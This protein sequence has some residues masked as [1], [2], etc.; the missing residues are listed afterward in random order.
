MF[1]NYK[2]DNIANKHS[3]N[4]DNIDLGLINSIRR[5]ILSEI[6][7]VAFY[8]EEHP[9]IEILYNNTP[10]HNEFMIHR[11]GLIP[12]HIKENIVENYEDNDYTFEL[13]VENNNPDIKMLNI[14]T[15]DFT[16]TYKDKVLTSKE[17][18]EI[19]PPNPITKN[20]I[21]ITRLR[22]NEKIHLKA[23]AIKR[24]AKLNSSFSPVS[25][26]NF[27]FVIDEEEANKTDNILDK[28]RSYFKDKYGEPSK[29]N[30]QIEPI[31]AL[32][33]KYLFKK[34]MEILVEK[35]ENLIIKLD[36]QEIEIEEVPNIP[37]SFNFKIDDEDDTLG[38][39]I[40]SILHNKYIRE[41]SK[42]ND[43]KCDYIG[44][45]CPH[46]LIKQLVVRFTLST[47]DKKQFYYFFSQNSRHII[48]IINETKEEWLKFSK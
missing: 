19:F 8:G 27:F 35:L 14:T 25:L 12:L 44:Y 46:P 17:L 34:A 10:L 15:A 21:L 20:H 32:S 39:L 1:N 41:N 9:S 40:Q 47:T 23:K 26:S 33:Y 37:N 22:L 31:N 36:N 28:E 5:V 2:F 42:F 7:V 24:T 18:N 48:K 11:I 3:F 16:G 43:I 6:P 29:I 38:N 13:N 30:F 45:I 4:I